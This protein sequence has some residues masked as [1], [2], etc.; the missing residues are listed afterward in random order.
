MILLCVSGLISPGLDLSH[1]LSCDCPDSPVRGPSEAWQGPGCRQRIWE[2]DISIDRVDRFPIPTYCFTPLS[3][4]SHCQMCVLDFPPDFPAENTCS[5]LMTR[6]AYSSGDR[7]LAICTL[8]SPL[9]VIIGVRAP[10][11]ARQSLCKK[12]RCDNSKLPLKLPVLWRAEI[13]LG[14]PDHY[15]LLTYKCDSEAR[16]LFTFNLQM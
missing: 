14:R 1:L 5:I 16:L 10:T 2:R 8:L 7:L 15:L 6:S 13:R 4:I 9:C 11:N 12:A 3:I